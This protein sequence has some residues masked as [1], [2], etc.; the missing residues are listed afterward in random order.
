[1]WR[2]GG[3]KSHIFRG[4]STGRAGPRGC[5]RVLGFGRGRFQRNISTV[6]SSTTGSSRAVCR[7]STLR[8]PVRHIESDIPDLDVA[9]SGVSLHGKP[10]VPIDEEFGRWLHICTTQN[11]LQTGAHVRVEVLSRG[12]GRQRPLKPIVPVTGGIGVV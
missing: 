8:G 9:R 7:C 6:S 2:G 10:V 3:L 1:M 11:T 5:T 12:V 4:D